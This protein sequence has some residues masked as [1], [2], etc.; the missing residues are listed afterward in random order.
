MIKSRV[1]YLTAAS[2]HEAGVIT[3]SRLVMRWPKNSWTKH[4]W[5]CYHQPESKSYRPASEQCCATKLITAET[6]MFQ[7]SVAVCVLSCLLCVCS[8]QS[9][10]KHQQHTGCLRSV[11]AITIITL[12]PGFVFVS[13]N[14]NPRVAR[15]DA[16]RPCGISDL[17]LQ[18][19]VNRPIILHYC[20]LSASSQ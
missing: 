13:V 9:H 18:S 10:L 15:G 7:V 2:K 14:L 20:F 11:T 12:S 5:W 16:T 4:D 8:H 1:Y 19:G 3:P 17:C 6:S